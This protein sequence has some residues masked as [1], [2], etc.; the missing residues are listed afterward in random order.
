[1]TFAAL[2][3][4]KKQKRPAFPL[5]TSPGRAPIVPP[6]HP[7]EAA[8]AA[9][10]V[11]RAAVAAAEAVV[12]R[13]AA[14]GAKATSALLAMTRAATSRGSMSPCGSSVSATRRD[15]RARRWRASAYVASSTSRPSFRA[16]CSRLKGNARCRRRTT[17]QWWSRACASST[18]RGRAWTTCPSTSCAADSLGFCL[19]S[20]PLTPSTM[21]RQ[22]VE[23]GLLT[24]PRLG[25]PAASD[26]LAA[27]LLH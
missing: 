16:W 15:A 12:V 18:A 5:Q 27:G 7:P 6:W 3:L 4:A 9:D 14:A 24:V 26:P 20:S 25:S 10:A 1:M 22:L 19:S 13:G 11:A 17:T 21:A 8:A 23:S 2:T